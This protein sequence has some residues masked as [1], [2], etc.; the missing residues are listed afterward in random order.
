LQIL[1][2]C[3]VVK[4]VLIA[5]SPITLSLPTKRVCRALRIFTPARWPALPGQT[6]SVTNENHRGFGSG[7]TV[8]ETGASECS[9][10]HFL[11]CFHVGMASTADDPFTPSITSNYGKKIRN[12]SQE[13]GP[14][15]RSTE[16]TA[17]GGT[18]GC[19]ER[20]SGSVGRI[21][22]NCPSPQ[23]TADS[24][25]PADC[26]PAIAIEAFS[27][28]FQIQPSDPLYRTISYEIFRMFGLTQVARLISAQ[29]SWGRYGQ[30]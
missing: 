7:L 27:G 3:P 4:I 24:E 30:I 16:G 29:R 22:P 14:W 20:A 9:R 5:G 11:A 13:R 10:E 23:K 15:D 8:W 12:R 2:T 18:G 21:R 17:G 1:A 25:K 26:I 28:L 19:I 6:G